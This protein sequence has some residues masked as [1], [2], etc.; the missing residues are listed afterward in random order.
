MAADSSSSAFVG[1]DD[2]VQPGGV[3]AF[4]QQVVEPDDL[5]R[6]P[7]LGQHQC[8]GWCV[9]TQNGLYVGQAE[10]LAQAV[11]PHDPLDPVIGLRLGK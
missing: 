6:G 1:L 8:R 2:D 7:D 11:D 3:A 10:R 9:G 5:V 4:G